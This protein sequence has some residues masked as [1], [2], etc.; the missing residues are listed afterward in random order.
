MVDQNKQSS[1]EDGGPMEETEYR[2]LVAWTDEMEADYQR[3]KLA[4]A[5]RREQRRRAERG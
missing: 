5:A 4:R 2:R 1:E 3:L